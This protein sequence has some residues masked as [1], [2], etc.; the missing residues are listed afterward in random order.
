MVENDPDVKNPAHFHFVLSAGETPTTVTMLP[1]ELRKKAKEERLMGMQFEMQPTAYVYLER[2]LQTLARNKGC[3][4]IIDYGRDEYIDDTL[5]GIRGH[6][7]ANPLSAPGEVDLSVF[8]SFK[9]LRQTMKRH[10]R[11]ATLLD[12][13]P[14]M[15]LR[16]QDKQTARCD[17]NSL[18]LRSCLGG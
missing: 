18:A 6:Q 15:S 17:D 12:C 5:R 1:H 11:L 4:L 2:I 13:T 14:V 9:M 7:F 10:D 8:V 16:L 3:F